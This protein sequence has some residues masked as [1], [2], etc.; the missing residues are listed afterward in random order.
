MDAHLHISR[1]G[2]KVPAAACDGGPDITRAGLEAAAG[3]A[4]VDHHIARARAEL[5][6]AC[7]TGDLQVTV[8]GNAP[9]RPLEAIDL[10]I[11]LAGVQGEGATAA[12]HGHIAGATPERPFGGEVLDPEVAAVG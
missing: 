4:V 10:D 7:H 6:P 5:R 2:A 12:V 11:A 8:S 9:G 3:R 1:A